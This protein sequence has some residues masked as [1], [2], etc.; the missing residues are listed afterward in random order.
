MA[1][2]LTPTGDYLTSLLLSLVTISAS[3]ALAYLAKRLWTATNL[4]AV[5]LLG[6]TFGIVGSYCG[7]KLLQISL[8]VLY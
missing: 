6:F 7:F 3:L 2:F 5:L 8:S 1:G 4:T